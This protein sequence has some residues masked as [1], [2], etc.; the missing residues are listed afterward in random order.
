MFNSGID[1]FLPR[2]K[3]IMTQFPYIPKIHFKISPVLSTMLGADSDWE[4]AI[5]ILQHKTMSTWFMSPV[6]HLTFG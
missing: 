4:A 5:Q 3:G 2:F 1:L 6:C